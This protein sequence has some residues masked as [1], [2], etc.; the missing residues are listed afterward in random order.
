LVNISKETESEMSTRLERIIRDSRLTVYTGNYVF[1]E[2]PIDEFKCR[3]N[4]NALAI[5]RDDQVWSQLIESQN[6][7]S[8]NFAM[9]RFHFPIGADNSGFV[10]WLATH[11]KVLFGTGVF[12]VCGQNSNDGGIFDYWG[13]PLELKEQIFGELRRLV[14]PH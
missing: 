14:N 3:V 11:L 12:V 1:E 4:E 2:F 13:C 5:V 6:P 9:W 10:G 7:A 8:E